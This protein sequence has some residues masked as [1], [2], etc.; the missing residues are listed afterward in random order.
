MRMVPCQVSRMAALLTKAWSALSRFFSSVV[1]DW[2]LASSAASRRRKSTLR[3]SFLEDGHGSFAP[4]LRAGAEDDMMAEPGELAADFE[5]DALVSAGD[6]DV[7]G[8]D[9]H[10]GNFRKV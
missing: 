9:A 5:A 2:M 7:L 4:F 10:G 1:A 6:E 8:G 3:P